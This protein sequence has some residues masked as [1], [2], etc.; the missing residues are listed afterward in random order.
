LEDTEARH[1]RIRFGRDDHARL[2]EL[3]SAD[4]GQAAIRYAGPRRSALWIIGWCL[5]A[6][7]LLMVML[8]AGILLFGLPGVGNDRLRQ[9]ME[10]SLTH[11]VGKDVQA[12]FADPHFSFDGGRLLGVRIDDF[13]IAN[14]ATDRTILAA[15][16]ISV[17]LRALPLLGGE[18]KVASAEISDAKLDLGYLPTAGRPNWLEKIKDGNGLVDPE[19][20]VREAFAGLHGTLE[21]FDRSSARRLD[22]TNVQ[23]AFPFDMGLGPFT[24]VEGEVDRASDGSVT[25][26]VRASYDGRPLDFEGV[27]AQDSATG[28]I[29]TFS[30]SLTVPEFDHVRQVAV[31][32]PH[33]VTAIAGSASLVFSGSEPETGPGSLSFKLIVDDATVSFGDGRKS[34][35]K[36]SLSSVLDSGKRKL[37]I[38]QGILEL[39]RSKIIA[40]GAV[41][42]APPAEGDKPHYRFELVSDGS[43]IAPEGS[44]EPDLTVLARVAGSIDASASRISANDIG[45]RTA[46]G[47]AIGSATV[48]IV[49]DKTP[50]LAFSFDVLSMPVSHAKQLW[51]W[52]AAA[53]AQI[54]ASGNLFGGTVRNSRLE[55][56]VKPGRIGDGIPLGRDEVAGHFEIHDTR[57]DIAGEIPPVRDGVGIVDFRGTDVDIELKAGTVYLPTGRTVATNKGKFLIRR[58][59]LPPVIGQLDIDIT[60][61]AD[62][63]AELATY[64]P[65]DALRQ[66]PVS[67]DEL[68]GSVSGNVKASIPLQKG[69]DFARQNWGVKLSYED[70]SISR[71]FEGQ[72]V[73]A[74]TGTIEVNPSRAII[75]ANAKLSGIPAKISMTEPLGPDKQAR[76]RDISLTLDDKARDAVAPGLSMLLSGPITLKVAGTGQPQRITADLKNA[77]LTVPWIGWSKGAGVPASVTFAMESSGGETR[78]SDLKLTG[79]T[80][81]VQGAATV[82]KSGLVRANFPRVRLNRN[83][84]V[85]VSVQRS[86]VGYSVNVKG[87]SL[88]ARSLMKQVM[89]DGGVGKRRLAATNRR[90]SNSRPLSAM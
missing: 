45:V 81:S 59:E 26:A 46:G 29:V 30:N 31:L 85:A 50:G 27:I 74:A 72:M 21:F 60:G 90:Q 64:K 47:E 12:S 40:H 23:I 34:A 79:G 61:T 89:S 17:G 70:L 68:S 20:V 2:D 87:E 66:L 42:P 54:W 41:G 39:G 4:P 10:N 7:V 36:A 33:T 55:L 78:I 52:F 25:Y 53:P 43:N 5:A 67:P 14:A 65:I 9:E 11:A 56:N 76:T 37:E 82:T 83:D 19:L 8:P 35:L 18:V 6:T 57:F 1:E 48:E 69:A 62:A 15:G 71:P 32:K 24:I 73:S 84:D 58:G 38:E 88:D 16:N 28:R 80:F 13:R 44:N 86:G 3:P 75:E 51:P 77:K 22:L 49:P 63:V